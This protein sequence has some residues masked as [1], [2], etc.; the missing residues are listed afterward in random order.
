MRVILCRKMCRKEPMKPSIITLLSEDKVIGLRQVN[1]GIKDNQIRCVLIADDTDSNIRLQLMKTC[2]EANVL[3][4]RVRSKEEL[5]K[6][7]G[8]EV[9]CAT[10]GILKE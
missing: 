1:R 8:I 6:A 3:V 10:V 9:D 5:G 4:T 2:R 7:L